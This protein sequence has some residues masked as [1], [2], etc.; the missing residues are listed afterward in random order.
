MNS[1]YKKLMK[2]KELMD[3]VLPENEEVS[4]IST[5]ILVLNLLFSGKADGGIPIGKVSQMAAPSSLGKSFIGLSILKNAQ[6]QGKYCVVLDTETAF[7]YD[8][9]KKI[10]IDIDREKLLIVQTNSI[11]ILQKSVLDILDGLTREE[12]REVFFLLDSFGGLITS[13]THENAQNNHDVMDM[14]VPKKKNNF[15]KLLMGTGATYFVVNHVYDNIGGFGDPLSIPGGRG[16][17]FASSCI[18]LGSSKAKEKNKSSGEI[19][20]SIITAKTYKSR[21]GKENSKL[22]FRIKSNGGLD[23]F[24]GLLE[25]ALEGGFVES[26][27]NGYYSRPCVK[28]DKPCK[29]VDIYTS[30]FWI[31]VLKN[32]SGEFINYLEDLYSFKNQNIDISNVDTDE[33]KQDE[34]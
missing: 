29:E 18:V 11:E 22:K 17:A 13:K 27:K 15:A 3:H 21:F 19:T 34:E 4:F 30:D 1:I 12:K 20:G 2:N 10:G 9:A 23:T 6:K 32:N 5:G 14:T 26:P 31:P 8:F 25:D 16:L 7:D 24:Y 33:L 28:D